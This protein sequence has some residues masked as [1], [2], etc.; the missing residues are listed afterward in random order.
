MNMKN[1]K[2]IIVAL[3]LLLIIFAGIV[4]WT[5]F[6]VGQEDLTEAAQDLY[7]SSPNF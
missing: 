1:H 6:F 4:F 3:V 2:L 5:R 7:S